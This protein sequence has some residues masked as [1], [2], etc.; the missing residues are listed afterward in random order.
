MVLTQPFFPLRHVNS[1]LSKLEKLKA[2]EVLWPLKVF[3]LS[4]S[5]PEADS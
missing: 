5:V 4:G 2:R 1:H 3:Q